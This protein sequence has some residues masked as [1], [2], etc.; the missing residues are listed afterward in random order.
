MSNKYGSIPK[1]GGLVVTNTNGDA[2]YAVILRSGDTYGRAGCLTWGSERFSLDGDGVEFYDTHN[3]DDM[4]E[5][6]FVTRHYISTMLEHPHDRG[7][8]LWGDVPKWT[9]DAPAMDA[10]ITILEQTITE[11]V[12]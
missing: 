9:I 11:E 4:A 12:K 5:W 3:S 6:Q 8:R 7:L 2:F 10:V 1:A